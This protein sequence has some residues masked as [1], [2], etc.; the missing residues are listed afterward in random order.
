MNKLSTK[1]PLEYLSGLFWAEGSL[2]MRFDDRY[3]R[4]KIKGLT[5]SLKPDAYKKTASKHRRG[6]IERLEL[7]LKILKEKYPSLEYKVYV[8]K[9][10][11][12]KGKRT[13]H[14]KSMWF[15][16]KIIDINP[17]NWRIFK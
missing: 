9:K 11:L 15:I 16:D 1:Y 13:F 14:I 4:P 7:I 8:E 5:I 17:C 6:T 12:D 10:G 3:R 2:D